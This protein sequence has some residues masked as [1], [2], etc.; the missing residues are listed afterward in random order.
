MSFLDTLFGSLSTLATLVTIVVSLWRLRRRHALRWVR[1]PPESMLK[2]ADD[3]AKS[4]AITYDGR[5]VENLRKYR[6]ILHNTGTAPLDTE[7]IDTPLTW[8]APGRIVAAWRG[9]SDPPVELSLTCD[10]RQLVIGWSLFNQRCKALIEVLCENVTHPLDSQLA[11]QIRGVP[12]V[13]EKEF[14]WPRGEA[15]IRRIRANVELQRG[16]YRLA[17]RII[18]TKYGIRIVPHVPAAYMIGAGLWILNMVLLQAEAHEFVL[19][20]GNVAAIA[21]AAFLIQTLRNPYV[22]LLRRHEEKRSES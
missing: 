12:K 10:N 11:G 16:L 2:V 9:A 17:G 6:F 19:V 8:H 18:A 7:A 20:S 22:R 4:V 15:A 1:F 5:P 3:V 21:I 14:D 13:E